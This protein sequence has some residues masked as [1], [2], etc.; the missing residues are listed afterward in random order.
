MCVAIDGKPAGLLAVADPVKASAAEAIA[1]LRADRA[2]DHHADWRRGHTAEA[3]AEKGLDD[4]RAAF[5][6]SRRAT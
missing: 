1:E 3:V 4:V 5:C 6:P 2:A